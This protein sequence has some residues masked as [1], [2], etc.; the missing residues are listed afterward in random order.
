MINFY[1]KNDCYKL[2]YDDIISGKTI[3]K[4]ILIKNTGVKEKYKDLIFASDGPKPE[5]VIIDSL[6][7]EIKIL[8]PILQTL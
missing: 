4:V 8:F 2:I 7:N 6:S 1:L 3:Y 5:I